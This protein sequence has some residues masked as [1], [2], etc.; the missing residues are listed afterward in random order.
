M[1]IKAGGSKVRLGPAFVSGRLSS[2][3]VS[4]ETSHLLTHAISIQRSG[5]LV[6]GGTHP[7]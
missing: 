1:H 7:K 2:R 5:G 6:M 4:L 3:I